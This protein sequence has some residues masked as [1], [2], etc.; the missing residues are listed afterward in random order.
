MKIIDIL[1]LQNIKG[2]G[3]KSVLFINN[4]YNISQLPIPELRDLLIDANIKNKRITIP[5]ISELEDAKHKAEKIIEASEN[6]GISIVGLND[7]NYPHLL[8]QISDPPTIL[9]CKGNM[10]ALQASY[11]LAVIGTREP[12]EYGLKVGRRLSQVF[13]ENEICIISG[14]AK[15]C[16]TVAHLGCIDAKGVTIAVLAHGL[17]KI[18]PKINT[19]LAE[20]IL[21]NNGCLISEYPV[22]TKS[23][24]NFF[25][26]R[27]RIQ[28]G[29]SNGVVV[30]ETDIKGGTMHTVSFARKQNRLVAALNSH[31]DSWRQHRK[32]LGNLSIIKNGGIPLSSSEEINLFIK[33]LRGE[34]VV[35]SDTLFNDNGQGEIFR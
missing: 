26:E 10:E 6:H 12:S 4:N 29:L 32:F 17:E 22:G 8:K 15:G 23:R 9:Y 2:F 3:I 7:D 27:D 20:S 35:E 14:L 11:N 25:I 1:T 5:L 34:I 33:Q 31:S 16:D 30:I 18:Y 21:D 24:P 19:S 13:A 28:S